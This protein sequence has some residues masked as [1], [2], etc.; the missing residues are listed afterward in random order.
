[1][2]HSLTTCDFLIIGGGILGL[3]LG[4]QLKKTFGNSNIIII[5]KEIDCGLHASGR[6]SGVLHAGFYYTSDSLKAKFTRLGNLALTEYCLQ[7]N[8]SINRCGKLV[9]SRNEQ[10][11]F[12]LSELLKRGQQNG[13]LLHELTDK[14]AKEIEPRV[15]TYH[16]ALFS[17]HTSSVDPKK[18]IDCLKADVQQEEIQIH[19]KTKYL[20]MKP[21]NIILTSK[22]KYQAGYV[23][24]A[25][26]LYA[27]KIAKDF[28]FSK[29]YSILPFKGIYL[30]SNEPIHAL[31]THIY[32]V[33]NLKNP[34][35]GVHVTITVDGRIKI[36][37]TAIPAFWREQYKLFNNFKLI[38][39][40][41]ILLK[42]VN[43]LMFSTFDFKSLAI[44]EL[45]KYSKSSLVHLAKLLVADVKKEQFTRFGVP[46]IR[47]QL[48]NTKTKSLEMDFIVEGDKHSMHILNN[49]SP[50]F[51]SSFPFSRYIVDQIKCLITGAA[52]CK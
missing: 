4:L 26:G 32:P 16:K 15:I 46:G 2:S 5:E 29:Q 48:L 36:G 9:V 43:L 39:L 8:I 30:Y 12:F 42:Q 6:N 23:I 7:K 41:D 21:H 18:I 34:F 51:T 20:K 47:A 27:D 11:L 24:N 17:P 3:S 13:V 40:M 31:R 35:L 19:Y 38:E 45:K 50:G 28:N 44:E 49:V 37:P 25:A 33:P 1:M 52:S 14:E 10:D 22:G